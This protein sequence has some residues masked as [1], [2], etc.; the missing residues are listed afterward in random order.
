MCVWK[1]RSLASASVLDQIWFSGFDCFGFLT[2][3]ARHRCRPVRF[4]KLVRISGSAKIR[5]GWLVSLGFF[6]I[7][8]FD[9]DLVFR[10]VS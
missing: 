9:L 5:K 2:V 7:C 1:L 3:V 6:Q 8:T 10:F 4:K